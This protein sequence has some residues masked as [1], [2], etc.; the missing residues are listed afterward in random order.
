M[1]EDNHVY[2]NAMAERVNGILKTEFLGDTEDIPF[3]MVKPFVVEAIEI[4][5]KERLHMSLNYR[6]PEQAHNSDEFLRWL[7]QRSWLY[8]PSE[9]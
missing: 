2:E 6:T 3:S 8:E 5:N 7:N 9:V 4:Y 1:T